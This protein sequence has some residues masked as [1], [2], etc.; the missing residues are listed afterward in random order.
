MALSQRIVRM[1]Q[2]LLCSP[3]WCMSFLDLS[4]SLSSSS[5]LPFLPTSLPPSVLSFSLPASPSPSL[6]L[7]PCLYLSLSLTLPYAV[8]TPNFPIGCNRLQ[9]IGML[10]VSPHFG[11]NGFNTSDTSVLL[12]S[13]R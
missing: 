2:F 12:A 11:A 9:P 1:L 7:P 13:R 8:A 4:L 5:L 3:N 6:Y 10:G